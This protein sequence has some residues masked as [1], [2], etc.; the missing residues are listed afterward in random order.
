MRKD[1]KLIIKP[2]SINAMYY[3]DARTK[4]SQAR[5]WSYQ[6]FHQL[7]TLNNLNNM[8]DLREYFNPT[9]HQV[10]IEILVEYPKNIFFTKNGTISAKTIDITNFEKVITDLFFDKRYFDKEYPYGCKN[11]NIDDKYITELFSK[12]SFIESD[13]HIINYSVIINPLKT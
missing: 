11:L 4:T 3:G 12:K 6:V 5:E 13:V 8:K 9:K 7:S 1:F 2:F 10:S